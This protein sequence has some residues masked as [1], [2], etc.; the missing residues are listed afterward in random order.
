VKPS[1]SEFPT[2]NGVRYHVRAWGKPSAKK[3]FLL[4]GWMDVAASFQFLVDALQGDWQAIAPDWRGFGQSAWAGPAYYFPDYLSDLD[5]LL[6][7]YQPDEPAYVVGHSMGG[8]VAGLYA[9]VR[10]QRVARLAL[11]EGFGL[12]PSRAEQAPA[13]YAKWLA[14]LRAPPGFKTYASFDELARRLQQNNPR[15]AFDRALFLARHCAKERAP[16]RIEIA[17]D[18]NHKSP[19]PVLYRLEEAKACWR[20]VSAPVLWVVGAQSELLKKYAAHPDDYAA[21][22]SCFARLEERV[23]EDAGHMLHHDQPQALGRL[24][25]EFGTRSSG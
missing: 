23:I 11:L 6:D 9:G 21:R 10:P 14:Q 8:N 18:P 22:K 24:L 5:A 20:N 1:N 12:A 2:F 25:E 19:N 17:S 3:I 7:Y 16:G 15:L 4:H 13:R